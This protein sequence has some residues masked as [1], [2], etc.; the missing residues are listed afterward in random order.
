MIVI[1]TP[2]G[3]IGRQVLENIVGSTQKIRVIVR[4]ASKIPAEIR[5]RVEIIEGSH[6]EA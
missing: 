5:E 2:T 6:G 1:T 3:A 4:D